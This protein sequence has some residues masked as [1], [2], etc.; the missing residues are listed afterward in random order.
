MVAK[1]V[2]KNFAARV[3]CVYGICDVC[4]HEMRTRAHKF[5]VIKTE[6]QRLRKLH[7]GMLAAGIVSE[8]VWQ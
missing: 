7:D 1:F 8:P 2:V 6:Q 4:V 3:L 5:L